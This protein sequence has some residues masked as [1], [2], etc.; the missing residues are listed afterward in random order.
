M[1]VL[2]STIPARLGCLLL[3]NTCLEERIGVLSFQTDRH[4]P[5]TAR[6]CRIPIPA[7]GGR[8][9]HRHAGEILQ[10]SP[11]YYLVRYEPA[12]SDGLKIFDGT[13]RIDRNLNNRSILTTASRDLY[14]RPNLES[15]SPNDPDATAE[16]R[17]PDPQ[18]STHLPNWKLREVASLHKV[19]WRRRG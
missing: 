13:V 19:A 3:T 4:A 10:C 5:A 6:R 18:P 7:S 14:E 1:P 17:G 8:P 9:T 15:D 2:H 11:G 16:S 12:G